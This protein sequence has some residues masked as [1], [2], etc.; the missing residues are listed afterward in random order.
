MAGGRVAVRARRPRSSRPRPCGGTC[1]HRGEATR[2]GVECQTVDG[3]ARK[4]IE[5]GGFGPGYT[6]STHRLG[7]GIG[8]DAHEWPYVVR[9]NRTKLTAGTTFTDEPGVY[10]PGELGI[11]LEDTVAV[12]ESGCENLAPKWSGTPEDPAVV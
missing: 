2:P 1:R 6:Y 4:A 9:G 3:A 5:D 7:H 12:T 10:V 11:R 8:L